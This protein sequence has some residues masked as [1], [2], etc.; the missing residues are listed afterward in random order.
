MA[1][2]RRWAGIIIICLGATAAS[3]AARAEVI[4]AV[5]EARGSVQVL[6]DGAALSAARGDDIHLDDEIRTGPKGAVGVSLADG[7][8]LTLGPRGR[9]VVDRFLYEPGAGEVGLGL[10]FL[11]GTLQYISGRIAQVSPESVRVGTPT[12]E[13]GIRGTR[14]LL[15]VSGE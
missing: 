6:R 4:G 14:F 2:H 1:S 11:T 5:K 7:T 12:G 15:K 10:S 13:I 8:L 9:L 3:G